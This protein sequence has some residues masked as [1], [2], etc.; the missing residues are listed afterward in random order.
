MNFD[1]SA[2]LVL[3]T[4]I[5]G[6]IWAADS[7]FFASKRK[8]EAAVTS[9]NKK[10]GNK[11]VHEPL[12]VDYARSFFPVFFIVLVLRSF[13]FEPFRI[14][15]AS[16]MPTLLIG[17]FILVNKFDYGIRLPVL[18]T[19]IISNNTPKRGDIIVFRY[20]E[21]PRIPFIK[22]VVAVS[23]DKVAY[24]EKTLYINGV[25]DRQKNDG[26]YEDDGPGRNM[27][28]WQ[29]LEATTGEIDHKILL[30]PQRQSQVVEKIVPEG[31]YFV[32]GDN[33]DNS[34]DSRFWGF[35]PDEN[36]MGR[37]FYIWMNW[38]NNRWWHLPSWDVEWTRIGTSLR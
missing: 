1:F 21:D 14:P 23:G 29:L 31:H 22:R 19:K 25:A 37:A 27:N 34:K 20:P 15:S 32:L 8:T 3:L 38:S 4:F 13:I 26:L 24:F 5:S 28:G 12:M 33:R 10:D 18:N 30:N 6:I 16:M 36:L 17:D 7:L 9:D 2:L 35:V 11:V